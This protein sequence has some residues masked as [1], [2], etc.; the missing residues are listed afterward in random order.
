L[1]CYINPVSST[2]APCH[3]NNKNKVLATSKTIY[4]IGSITKTFVGNLYAQL[5]VSN[6]LDLSERVNDHLPD[7]RFP[8]D[9]IGQDITI[10]NL[11][12]HTAGL[13]PYPENLDRIDG[14][15][16]LKYSN[17]QMLQAI[18]G[19]RLQGQIGNKW[20]Y[21]NFGYDVL[22]MYLETRFNW[23]EFRIQESISGR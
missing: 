13:P 16:I 21:S 20:S 1:K 14:E 8:A 10:L 9:S 17:Q 7:A 2:K 23:Q 6:Q 11:L 12:T 19:T 22:G 18:G 5:A 4:Q 3:D 15:P